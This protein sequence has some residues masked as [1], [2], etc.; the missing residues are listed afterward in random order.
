MATLTTYFPENLGAKS[1]ANDFTKILK[2]LKRGK[3]E[4]DNVGRLLLT[5]EA[6]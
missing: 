4:Y 2:I 6:K 1:K 5:A 3:V